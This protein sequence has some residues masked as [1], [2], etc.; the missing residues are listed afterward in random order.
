LAAHQTFRNK[1][2]IALLP[3]R[4]NARIVAQQGMFTV[5][6]HERR[7]LDAYARDNDRIKMG[8]ILLDRAR[9]AEVMADLRGIGGHRVAMFPEPD[10]VASH[11]CWVCQSTVPITWRPSV[12]KKK[13]GGGGGAT[14]KAKKGSKKKR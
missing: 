13:K 10:S 6:G 3:A 4:A 5:H 7:S 2:P 1:K 11:V 14:I 9:L 8:R 12:A